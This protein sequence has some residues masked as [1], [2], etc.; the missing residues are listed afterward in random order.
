MLALMPAP[1][2]TVTWWPWARSFLTVS[3]VAATRVSPAWVSKGI[4]MCIPLSLISGPERGRFPTCRG[5]FIRLDVVSGRMNS[6]LRRHGSAALAPRVEGVDGG[7]EL[8]TA[9][10]IEEAPVLGGEL[11]GQRLLQGLA[12]QAL[13]AGQRV[14]RACGQTLG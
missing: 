1:L 7:E 8:G 5:E 13:E 2:W 12:Q 11:L 4:P 3:G 6:P 14:R 10:A 9:G